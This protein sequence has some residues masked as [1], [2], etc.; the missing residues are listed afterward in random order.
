MD[1]ELCQLDERGSRKKVYECAFVQQTAER[2]KKK[3]ELEALMQ[4]ITA[5]ENTR[6][7]MRNLMRTTMPPFVNVDGCN[8]ESVQ[9]VYSKN[10]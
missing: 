1:L 6:N 3:K 4:M 8:N 10:D 2:A 9:S 5:Q 7:S